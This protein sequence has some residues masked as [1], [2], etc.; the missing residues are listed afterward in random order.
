MRIK[1]LIIL[2]IDKIKVGQLEDAIALLTE[3]LEYDE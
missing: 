2:S 3:A 1:E